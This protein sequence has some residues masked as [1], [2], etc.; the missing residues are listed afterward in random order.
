MAAVYT[1]LMSKAYNFQL[2]LTGT[3]Q[4]SD[5]ILHITILHYPVFLLNSRRLQSCAT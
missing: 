2:S 1:E 4:V 3:G 5:N